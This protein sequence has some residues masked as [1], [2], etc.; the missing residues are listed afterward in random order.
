MMGCLQIE[1]GQP[2]VAVID[3]GSGLGRWSGKLLAQRR[4]VFAEMR[5]RCLPKVILRNLKRDFLMSIAK[6]SHVNLHRPGSAANGTITV[7]RDSADF[8]VDGESL[9]GRLVQID[10]GHSDFMGCFVHGFADAKARAL[11]ELLLEGDAASERHR[12]GIYICPEC[13]DIGCGR[14]SMMVERRDDEVIWS[15]FGY[16]NG[17][18]DLRIFEDV[19]PFRFES[20]HYE[21]SL[22]QA[23][24]I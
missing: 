3:E 11:S 15:E 19:G 10:G 18:E 21:T 13:G 22:R 8:L 20:S 6:L 12:V 2:A 14:F 5:A 4:E 23:A 7:Q 17:Y 16:E 9:L 24:E 1:V